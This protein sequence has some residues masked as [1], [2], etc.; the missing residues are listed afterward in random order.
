MMSLMTILLSVLIAIFYSLFIF[1]KKRLKEEGDLEEFDKK[2]L[3]WTISVGLAV[4][5]IAAYNGIE[6]TWQN[7]GRYWPILS[8]QTA[9]IILA[10]HLSKFV[11][12]IYHKVQKRWA[13]NSL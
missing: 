7:I 3:A 4:G 8:S 5:V 6:L 2:K 1:V 12:R 9:V 11:M 10:D 13:S